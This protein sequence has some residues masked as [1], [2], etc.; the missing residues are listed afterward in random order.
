MDSIE[1]KQTNGWPGTI[2]ERGPEGEIRIVLPSCSVLRGKSDFG[3][4]IY[5]GDSAQLV[6]NKGVAVID[7][8]VS[9]ELP[10]K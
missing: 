7:M 6:L 2:I 3:T 10:H 4:E 5:L 1:R 9:G 8:I